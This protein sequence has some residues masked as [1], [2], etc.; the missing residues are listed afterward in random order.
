MQLDCSL[1]SGNLICWLGGPAVLQAFSRLART[2][3][4][5]LLC[6]ATTPLAGFQVSQSVH[7]KPSS[8]A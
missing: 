2:L 7:C 5:A 3:E 8:T 4:P 1:L 6:L